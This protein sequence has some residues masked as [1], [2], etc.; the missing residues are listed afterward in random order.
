MKSRVSLAVIF[1]T[2][3]IDLVGFGIVIPLI[4]VYGKHFQATTFQLGVLGAAYSVMQFFFSPLWGS[5]SDKI[6]RRPV[7]LFSLVGSTISYLLFAI[8]DSYALLL[9]SRVLGGICAA[10]IATAQSYIADIT[11]A[12]KRSSG[13]GLIGAAFGLGFIF[14]PPLG[15][16]LAHY[17]GLSAP[18]FGAALVCGINAIAAWFRLGESLPP[19]KRGR[20]KERKLFTLNSKNLAMLRADPL[21]LGL[22]V[23]T[24]TTTFTFSHLEQCFA[25]LFQHRFFPNVEEAAY[26]TG[27]VLGWS[28]ILGALVQGVLIRKLEVR[29]S[30]WSRIGFG[31]VTSGLV[32]A[33]YPFLPSYAYYFIASIPLAVGGGFLNPSL[34]AAVSKSAPEHELGAVFGITQGVSSLARAVGPFSAQ[35]L[36]GF[37][38]AAPFL[39]AGVLNLL[40]LVYVAV[41]SRR[42]SRPA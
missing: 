1:I 19:E 20:A 34:S 5:L 21:L 31:L 7:L 4:S 28:G 25:L 18:G 14:G 41:L 2:V 27:M 32:Y 6:G 33:L 17:G 16:V 39:I 29:Y 26:R 35:M 37:Y 8:A 10:N 3:F 40:L 24:F 9:A 12:E 23:M 15:G 13:M 42:T 38:Y 36:F 22:C 11:P 30:D